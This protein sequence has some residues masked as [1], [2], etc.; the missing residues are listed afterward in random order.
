MSLVTTAELRAH[1]DLKV[2]VH[3]AQAV[4]DLAEA[5]VASFLS[6]RSEERGEPLGERTYTERILVPRDKTMI[7][8]TGGPIS[9]IDSILYDVTGYSA[10]NDEVG[11]PPNTTAETF[12]SVFQPNFQGWCAFGR[13]ADGSPFTFRA[14]VEYTVTYRV[15]WST[16][17]IAHKWEFFRTA[18]SDTWDDATDR[19]DWG[20]VDGTATTTN[21]AGDYLFGPRPTTTLEGIHYETGGSVSDDRLQ[22]PTV[23]IVGSRHPF[24][25]VKLKLIEESSSGWPVLRVGWTD[26]D[27]RTYFSGKKTNRTGGGFLPDRLRTSTLTGAHAGY[28]ALVA[29]MGYQAISDIEDGTREP[30]R[31]WIDNT[32]TQFSLEL[33]KG[34]ASDPNGALYLIDYIAVMDGLSKTPKNIKLGVLE[35]CRAL[36]A[37]SGSGVAAESVGD[38]SKTL[39]PGEA[40][41]SIPP[42]ARRL[43]NAYRRAQW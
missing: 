1:L 15:G 25:V 39:A 17:S 27:G 10:T 40:F 38:Y 18:S 2:D 20:F 9:G 30:F 11:D 4:L 21:A 31:G 7:E 12:S 22:S 6:M 14:G 43:L 23:S 35:T 32:I 36:L 13:N 19:L 8:V 42:A 28:T 41:Y 5:S 37:G 26:G 3:R 33:W 16:G 29:D 24:I 34:G